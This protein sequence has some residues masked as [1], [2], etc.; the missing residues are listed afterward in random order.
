MPRQVE[1]IPTKTKLNENNKGESDKWDDIIYF[2]QTLNDLRI[3]R[4]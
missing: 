3:H 1:Q 4:V 2:M